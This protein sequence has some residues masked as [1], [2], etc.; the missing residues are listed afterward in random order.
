[1]IN[2]D[3]EKQAGLVPVVVQDEDTKDVLM[4]AY[5]NKE[6]FELTKETGFAHYFSRSRNA[7]WKKGETSGNLQKVVDIRL[8]CDGDTLLYTVRQHGAACHT[9]EWSCFFTKL[10]QGE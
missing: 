1:M 9:G 10:Y 4:L 2:L 7:L 5:A 6:A 3:W 8:D